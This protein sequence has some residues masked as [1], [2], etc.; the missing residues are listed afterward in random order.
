MDNLS[1]R[2]QQQAPQQAVHVGTWQANDNSYYEKSEKH[3]SDIGYPLF[4]RKFVACAW[5]TIKVL[6]N[7]YLLA[8]PFAPSPSSFRTHSRTH[9]LYLFVTPLFVLTNSQS[10]WLRATAWSVAVGYKLQAVQGGLQGDTA[11]GV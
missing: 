3:L 9:S 5:S 4:T 7:M 6:T 11:S 2:F 10:W 8:I 1:L